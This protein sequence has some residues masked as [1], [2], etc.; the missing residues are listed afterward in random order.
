MAITLLR[1]NEQ[2]TNALPTRLA[3][4]RRW[5]DNLK[6]S[7]VLEPVELTDRIRWCITHKSEAHTDTYPAADYC[8]AAYYSD[9]RDDC[10]VRDRYVVRMEDSE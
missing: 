9:E 3:E 5:I 1:I 6:Q 8:Q 4:E 2:R 10:F 7:R